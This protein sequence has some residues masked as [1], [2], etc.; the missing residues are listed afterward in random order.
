MDFLAETG[1]T[2]ILPRISICFLRDNKRLC[3]ASTIHSHVRGK[4][5]GF[6]DSVRFGLLSRGSFFVQLMEGVAKRLGVGVKLLRISRGKQGWIL[7]FW[8]LGCGFVGS[9]GDFDIPFSQREQLQT[10]LRIGKALLAQL[11]LCLFWI[12]L[13]YY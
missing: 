10:Q 11:R 4:I 2:P 6:T 3:V 1:I 12:V 5:I 7:S 9:R 8:L 13:I